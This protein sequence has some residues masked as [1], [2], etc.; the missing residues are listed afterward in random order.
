MQYQ[1]LASLAYEVGQNVG[2]TSTTFLARINGFLNDRYDDALLRSGA[3]SWTGASL[4]ALG[5][6]DIPILGLG[7][8]I[9]QGATADAWYAKKQYQKATVH[10]QK[11]EFALANFVISGDY[12]TF[13]ISVCRYYDYV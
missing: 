4:S 3:T 8:V 5:D 6:S 13:N 12:N 11:Y 1:A 10:D 2:D 7:K 9:K